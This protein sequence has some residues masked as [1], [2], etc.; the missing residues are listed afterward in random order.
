MRPAAALMKM[1]PMNLY[2][3]SGT[4]DVND[5]FR[6]RFLYDTLRLVSETKLP[7]KRYYYD[8]FLDGFN[9]LD[10]CYARTGLVAVDFSTMERS[11]KRSG[12][13]YARI[14]R[15]GGVNEKLYEKYVAGEAYHL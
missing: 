3:C 2:L 14:I 1:R 6:A 10:G 5:S 4:C 9:Y 11:V 7:V 15:R 12:E 8:G 13:L